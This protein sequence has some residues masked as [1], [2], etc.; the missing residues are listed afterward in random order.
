MLSLKHVFLL[1]MAKMSLVID[2]RPSRKQVY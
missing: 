1:G 2:A